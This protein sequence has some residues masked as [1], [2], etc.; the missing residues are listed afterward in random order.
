[1]VTISTKLDQIAN[2][3]SGHYERGAGDDDPTGT[4]R[5]VFIGSIDPAGGHALL[6][7]RCPRF[8][9][10]KEPRQ[11]VL[12]PGDL[13]IPAR[14]NRVSAALVSNMPDRRPLVA[15]S[16]LHVVRP[17]PSAV[18]P[19]YLAWWFNSPQGQAQVHERTRGTKISF[20]PLRAAR[21]LEL[22]LPPLDVQRRVADLHRLAERESQILDNIRTLRLALSH[23]LIHQIAMGAHYA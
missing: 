3:F 9:P 15:A 16:F 2:V 11:A 12:Q 10:S 14:G 8:T 21:S 13:V 1:M 4:H 22:P 17:K 20:L 19:A 7:D 6:R 23:T 18:E 5:L